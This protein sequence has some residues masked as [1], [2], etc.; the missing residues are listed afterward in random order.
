[1]KCPA[2][3][4]SWDVRLLGMLGGPAILID[5][6]KCIGC[7]TCERI[8][9]DT[10][11]EITNKRLSSPMWQKGILGLIVNMNARV[12]ELAVTTLHADTQRLNKF[13]RTK[14]KT[15]IARLPRFVL[16]Y[17]NFPIT[18]YYVD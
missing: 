18:R 7:M 11:I 12:I 9:P 2:N 10:A 16:R 3:A 4:I 1:M 8:C 13:G 6:N 14:D 15:W 5:L 17:G